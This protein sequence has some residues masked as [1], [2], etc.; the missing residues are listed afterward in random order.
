MLLVLSL[1][2]FT[3]F[4]EI[5]VFLLNLSLCATSV[6]PV[7]FGENVGVESTNPKVTNA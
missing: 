2:S 5:W 4:A 3:V 7:W 6:D 1:E